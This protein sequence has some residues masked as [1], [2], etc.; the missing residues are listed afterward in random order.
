MEPCL[1]L[2]VQIIFNLRH[3]FEPHKILLH[4]SL[5]I[6]KNFKK[7]IHFGAQWN[8]H[9]VIEGPYEHCTSTFRPIKNWAAYFRWFCTIDSSVNAILI[10]VTRVNGILTS[11]ASPQHLNA[12]DVFDIDFLTGIALWPFFLTF[13]EYCGLLLV[14]I[15]WWGLF[16]PLFRMANVGMHCLARCVFH[17]KLQDGSFKLNEL[18]MSVF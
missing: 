10:T 4:P 8:L 11:H 5:A 12:I 3:V 1:V 6:Y 7:V 2:A 13:L 9:L 16:Q 18:I 14:L 17:E 15:C